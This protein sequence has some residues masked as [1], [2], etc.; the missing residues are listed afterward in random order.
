MR[1]IPLE[2]G[3]VFVWRDPY[4]KN[5]DGVFKKMMFWSWINAGELKESL[6]S[7]PDHCD[8]HAILVPETNVKTD[9]VD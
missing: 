5:T 9:A 3:L 2:K 4:P 6:K 8:I 7:I 1:N